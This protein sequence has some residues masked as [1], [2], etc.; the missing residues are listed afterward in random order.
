MGVNPY[1]LKSCHSKSFSHRS[2]FS[3]YYFF[4]CLAVQQCGLLPQH[5]LLSPPLS[6][7]TFVLLPLQGASI[8]CLRSKGTIHPSVTFVCDL[9]RPSYK[10]ISAAFWVPLP[11]PSQDLTAIITLPAVLSLCIFAL[12]F[13][14]K[15]KLCCGSHNRQKL[16]D[17]DPWSLVYVHAVPKLCN[18]ESNPCCEKF[19]MW[20]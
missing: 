2:F 12:S 4:S 20:N 11:S 13:L 1:Q 14:K 19:Y 17:G 5:G 7:P 9:C 6:V 16:Q 15:F 8:T 18:H 10:S 3:D